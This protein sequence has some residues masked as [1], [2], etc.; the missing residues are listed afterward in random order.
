MVERIPSSSQDPA[1][2]AALLADAYVDPAP[3]LADEMAR[4]ETMY[5]ARAEGGELDSFFLVGRHTLTLDS[6]ELDLVYLGLSATRSTKQGTGSVGDLYRA[7]LKDARDIEDEEG[8]HLH[9]WLTCATPSTCFA[10]ELVLANV[11]PRPDGTFSKIAKKLA[12]ALAKEEGATVSERHPF[13]WKAHSPKSRYS[14]RERARIKEL[15]SRKRFTLLS[16]LGVEETN[17]DRLVFICGV[18]R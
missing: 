3:M 10:A 11:Q 16:D 6:G 12:F 4:C 13:V 15:A 9:L 1:E 17:G 5:L 2:L 14:E 8:S 7:F 18:P